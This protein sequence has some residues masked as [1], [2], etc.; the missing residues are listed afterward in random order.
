VDQVRPALMEAA[1]AGRDVVLDMRAAGVVDSAGLGLLVRAHRAA[2]QH[3]A[4]LR[5]V[6]PTRYVMTVLHTMHLD[7]LFPIYPD[8]RAALAE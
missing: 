7:G 4:A 5:L 1:A 3:G 2:R 8:E 6:A